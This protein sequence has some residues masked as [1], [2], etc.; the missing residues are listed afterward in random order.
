M[1]TIGKRLQTDMQ[2]NDREAHQKIDPA[3]FFAD[4]LTTA[5]SASSHVDHSP[6]QQISDNEFLPP[7]LEGERMS[8]SLLRRRVRAGWYQDDLHSQEANHLIFLRWLVR[9]GLMSEWN[10]EEE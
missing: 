7:P 1:A 6:G 10:E 2:H 5:S 3:S 9:A 4:D 8:L